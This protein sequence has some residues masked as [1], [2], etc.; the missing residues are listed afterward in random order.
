[1]AVELIPQT[2]PPTVSME[3]KAKW[4]AYVEK[5]MRSEDVSTDVQQELYEKPIFLARNVRKWKLQRKH[6]RRT[7]AEAVT[8][9]TEPDEEEDKLKDDATYVSCYH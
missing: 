3:E 8:I 9:K 7:E 2:E 6:K 5:F 4:S 1:M